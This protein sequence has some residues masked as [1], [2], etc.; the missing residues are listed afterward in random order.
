MGS[1]VMRVRLRLRQIRVLGVLVDTPGGLRVRVV[2]AVTRPRCRC[3][4]FKCH[5][6]HD[7][8]LREVRGLEVSGR[9]TTLVWLRRRLVCGNCG[10]RWLEGHPEFGGALTCRLARRLVADAQAMP[11][12][13]VVRRHG[14]GW[15]TVNALVRAWS[16]LIAEHRRSRRCSVLLVDETSM[17]K[18]RRCVTVI[19]NGDTGK[20]PAMV[21]HRDSAALN[22]FLMSQPHRW[23]RSVKV[24]ATD[25]SKAYKPSIE[26]CLP[27]ARHVL[28]RFHL[29]RWFCAGLTAVRRDVQRRQPQG[30]KPVFDPQVSKTRFLLMR[31]HDQL[32]DADQA[33]LDKLFDAHPRLETGWQALQELHGLYLADDHD[34]ALEALDR[35]CDLYQTGELPEF[36]HIVDAIIS[37]SDEI[38]AFHHTGRVSNGR[39]ENTDNL[40][41]VMR[42]TAHGFT[43]PT[44][45]AARGLLIT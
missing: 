13:A 19:V 41:Q 7:T 16:G 44:N 6:V 15:S 42:R 23:R 45:F 37:S 17:R 24:V 12:R 38:L 9:H 8:R 43:N 33:R 27:H 29:I 31:R 10:E 34:G 36:H 5:R 11:I 30:V 32:N 21:E 39:T 20:T 18:R 28:D 3:C 40:L 14:V 4:G 1:G 35:F 26:A 25:G 2:S 22:G